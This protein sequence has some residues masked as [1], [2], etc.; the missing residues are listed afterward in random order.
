MFCKEVFFFK[1]Y[2]VY[3]NTISMALQ[4]ILLKSYT[5]LP[6]VSALLVILFLPMHLKSS[7]TS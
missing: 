3:D 4:N 7:F 2:G 1:N 6:V 5:F